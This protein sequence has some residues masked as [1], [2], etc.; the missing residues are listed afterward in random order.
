[1]F[2]RK[3]TD[4]D[5]S[6]L[7]WL[8]IMIMVLSIYVMLA[9][10]MDALFELDPRVSELIEI[11]DNIVC[12][13]FF[14]EFVIRITTSKDKLGYL[15]WGWLDLLSSIPMVDSLRYARVLRLIRF[16]RVVRAF[17]GANLLI[18]HFFR[19]KA[20]G[21]FFSVATISLLLVMLGSICVLQV[22]TDPN[23]NIKTPGDALWWSYVTIMTVG[24]G[25]KYPVTAEG[26]MVGVVL[27]T[28]GVGL[29][30][31]LSGYVAS[32]FLSGFKKAND[33]KED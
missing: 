30:S 12:L 7:N 8:N 18:N 25:D 20:Q 10:M 3:L 22:E 13:L 26:R 33:K 2:Y 16:I 14:S 23:S 5:K 15:K 6:E 11:S 24:Y 27:M 28:V 9:I 32:W 29:V 21:A 4:S 19:N 17:F 31:T 1:M